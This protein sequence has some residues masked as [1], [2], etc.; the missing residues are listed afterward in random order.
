MTLRHLLAAV[1]LTCLV[2]GCGSGPTRRITPSTV[3][4]QQL[5]AQTNGEWRLTLRIQNYST[6]AMRYAALHGTLH[7]AGVDVGNIELKPD[8]D[9]PANSA[10]V[11]DATLHASAKLPTGDVDYKI[12][13][14]IETS[15]PKADFKF[16]RSSRLSPAPGLPGTWR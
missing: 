7:I 13:G 14:T 8:I 12:A 3:S 4:I 11:V 5:I 16:E 1:A 9:I 6:V 10:E 2:S 15:E